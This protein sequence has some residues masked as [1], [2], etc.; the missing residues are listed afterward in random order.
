MPKTITFAI[1]E[2]IHGEM[3]RADEIVDE[4]R[5]AVED[6]AEFAAAQPPPKPEEGLLNVFAQGAVPLRNT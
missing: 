2:G 1:L 6:A 4:V 5:K 3:P